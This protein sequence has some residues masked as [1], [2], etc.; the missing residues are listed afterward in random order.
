[1]ICYLYLLFV[2]QGFP[3]SGGSL[4][5]SG[6]GG[7]WEMCGLCSHS[8]T[9]HTPGLSTTTGPLTFCSV[10]TSNLVL[11]V[12]LCMC[13]FNGERVTLIYL[14][15][16]GV[17]YIYKHNYTSRSISMYS[18]HSLCI[19][20]CVCV[21]VCCQS[22]RSSSGVWGTGHWRNLHRLETRPRMVSTQHKCRH[23]YEILNEF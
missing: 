23:H 7:N 19:R 9:T 18:T 10:R 15:P 2:I 14:Q 16:E 22:G 1:M 4:S 6:C 12:Y 21:C 3:H 20:V 17:T 11:Y 8:G 5:G 13:S